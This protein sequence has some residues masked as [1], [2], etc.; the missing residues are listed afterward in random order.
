MSQLLIYLIPLVGLLTLVI[1]LAAMIAPQ[2]MSG[3]FGIQVS[4]NA[5]GLVIA[6]GV[7]DLCIGGAIFVT[8]MADLILQA[9]WIL[10]FLGVVSFSDFGCV[11]KYGSRFISYTHLIG[12]ILVSGLGFAL[13]FLIN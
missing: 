1:G 12:A 4:G 10:L 5:L 11:F 8:Y 3:I 13:V 6:M 9:G 7:R 2:K